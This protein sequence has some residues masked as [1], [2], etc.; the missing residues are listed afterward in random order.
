MRAANKSPKTFREKKWREDNS[1]KGE[2]KGTGH[3]T[4]ENTEELRGHGKNK[5]RGTQ[6]LCNKD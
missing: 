1:G 6:Y 3:I 5:F 4:V 2:G